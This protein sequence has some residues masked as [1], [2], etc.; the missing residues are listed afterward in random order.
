MVRR[1]F[2]QLWVIYCDDKRDTV[3][4]GMSNLTI[5]AAEKP[6]EAMT[7]PEI[8]QAVAGMRFPPTGS[9]AVNAKNAALLLLAKDGLSALAAPATGLTIAYTAMFIDDEVKTSPHRLW[10][11]FNRRRVVR[12]NRS[13]V[14]KVGRQETR[15]YLPDQRVD[16]AARAF[17]ILQ[18]HARRFRRWRDGLAWFAVIWLLLT[19]IAYW[20]AGLGR[21][22]LD[23]VDQNWKVFVDQR[24]DNPMLLACEHR[25]PFKPD[26][27]SKVSEDAA[28]A[29]L[30]CRRHGY[31]QWKGEAGVREVKAVFRCEQV[32]AFSKLFH[33]WCWR[34][35][36]TIRSSPGR[37]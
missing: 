31:Q 28:R 5:P 6:S 12:D 1:S 20:D 22:A 36:L 2:Q 8:I 9:D 26:P 30:D 15:A 4:L 32:S 29:E 14:A 13:G 7:A 17:P 21:A 16:L 19:A 11:W 35:L 24:R 37:Y 25:Q 10:D 27:A 33:V 23:R 3:V 34:W 18:E